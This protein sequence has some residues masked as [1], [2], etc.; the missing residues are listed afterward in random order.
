MDRHCRL[1]DEEVRSR[2][3]SG[4][5]RNREAVIH[6]LELHLFSPILG[7]AALSNAFVL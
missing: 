4:Q 7:A 2:L 5:R 6:F 1:M 3:L